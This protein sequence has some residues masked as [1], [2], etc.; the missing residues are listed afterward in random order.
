MKK[1]KLF[2]ILNATSG[3]GKA[4]DLA[5]VLDSLKTQ[6]EFSF[7][8]EETDY[9]KHASELARMY[10]EKAQQLPGQSICVVLGGDGTVHEVMNGLGENF[11]DFPVAFIPYGSGNDF[12]RSNGIPLKPLNALIDLLKNETPTYKDVIRCTQVET[13][14]TFYAVNSVG[15]GLDGKIIYEKSQMNAKKNRAFQFSKFSYLLS[16]FSAYNSQ[17]L[18][19]GVIRTKEKEWRIDRAILLLNANHASFGG[20]IHI[21]PPATS[22]D[23]L[24]D[25][26][27]VEKLMFKELVSLLF[28][29]LMR[30]GKHLKHP[31]V[32]YLQMKE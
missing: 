15:F 23:Q 14:D 22:E 6:F 28:H 25:L 16:V 17:K 24:L 29:V 27:M 13:G 4:K 18:F 3:T 2:I 11:N 31:K 20:G 21:L 12:A 10:A 1:K 7:E 32:H 8:I 30:N 19:S 9:R 26:L 5:R